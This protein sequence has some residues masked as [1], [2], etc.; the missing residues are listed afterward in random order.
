MSEPLSTPESKI[1]ETQETTEQVET[2]AEL[3]LARLLAVNQEV[4]ALPHVS[5]FRASPVH[6]VVMEIDRCIWMNTSD[7]QRV[8]IIFRS[9]RLGSA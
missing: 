3:T 9:H 5:A 8:T 7:P 4:S 2:L 6:S 1:G